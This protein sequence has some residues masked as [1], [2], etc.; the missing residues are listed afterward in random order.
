MRTLV[1][2]RRNKFKNKTFYFSV[3]D[4][5]STIDLIDSVLKFRKIGSYLISRLLF[6]KNIV[7]N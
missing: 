1:I 5:I 7:F 4:F 3:I 6:H 2:D